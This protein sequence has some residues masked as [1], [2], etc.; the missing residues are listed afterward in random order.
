MSEKNKKKN[1]PLTTTCVVNTGDE[2]NDAKGTKK[3]NNRVVNTV[4]MKGDAN[5]T[6]N[7]IPETVVDILNLARV[8]DGQIHEED[9]QKVIDVTTVLIQINYK[10]EQVHKIYVRYQTLWETFVAEHNITN[11]YDDAWLLQVS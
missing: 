5:G 9:I 2:R 3:G 4:V 11:E 8:K 10:N 1:L 6:I 7:D